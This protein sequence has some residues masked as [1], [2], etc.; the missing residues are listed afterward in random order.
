MKPRTCWLIAISL[1]ALTPLLGQEARGTILGRIAD[2][3]GSL[4]VGAKVEATNTAT[5]VHYTSTSNGTGDYILPFLIPGAYDLVVES[6]GFRTSKRSGIAVRESDRVTIDT[7]MQV[8]EASQSVQVMAESPILDTSTGSRLGTITGIVNDVPVLNA[9]TD[10]ILLVSSTGLVQC[11]REINLPFPV[12]HYQIEPQQKIT[13]AAPKT[14]AQKSED[15]AAPAGDTD[16]FGPGATKPATPSAGATD[17]FAA[18]PAT[19]P[20]APPAGADPFAKP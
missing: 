10:R 6:R 14:E 3:S 8:G 15:K 16:P 4:I 7:T 5:G 9:Q 12:V 18:P 2:Q 1:C 11:L 13:K 20:A 19:K 17:P